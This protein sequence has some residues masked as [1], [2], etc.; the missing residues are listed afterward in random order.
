MFQVSTNYVLWE[1]KKKQKSFKPLSLWVRFYHV[2]YV[3]PQIIKPV[4]N[5]YVILIF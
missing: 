2:W 3:L 4:L 1:I 5:A